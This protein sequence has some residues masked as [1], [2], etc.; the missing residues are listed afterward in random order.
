MPQIQN[1][2]QPNQQQPSNIRIYQT[3]KKPT[4][5]PMPKTTPPKK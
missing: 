1:T 4:K 3:P 2:Q 5:V